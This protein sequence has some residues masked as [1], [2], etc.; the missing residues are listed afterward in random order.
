MK[1]IAEIKTKSPFGYQASPS[2]GEMPDQSVEN[3]LIELALKHGNWVAVHTD[4][5]WGG[6]FRL[7]QKVRTMTDK[8][9]L[10]KGI[11]PT[12]EYIKQALDCGADYVLVIG[13]VPP[14]QYWNRIII[15]PLTL[16]EL[17]PVPKDI[18]VLWNTR[19]PATGELKEETVEEARALREGWF[20]H[21]SNI[22]SRRDVVEGA[23]A[24]LVGEHLEAIV[25]K[26]KQ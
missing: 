15:E 16:T 19:C 2:P 14:D 8:P 9:I 5:R 18:K 6:S 26:G 22:E 20:C 21:A 4:E 25:S 17:E 11:H 10:A 12:D 24:F 1:F 13:R 3:R 7:L 23:D